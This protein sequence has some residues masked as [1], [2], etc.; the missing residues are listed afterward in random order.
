MKIF[1]K[2]VF[3]FLGILFC[4]LM[5]SQNTNFTKTWNLDDCIQYAS[6]H[7]ININSLKLNE[8]SSEQDVL[9]AKAIKTPSLNAL[10]NNIFHNSKN[11]VL[12]TGVYQNQL[13]SNGNYSLNA[14]LVLWNGNAINNNI[15]QKELLQ[16]TSNLLVTQSTNN[17][18]LA[19]TQSYLSVLLAKE[20][21]K[22]IDD[23]VLT[24]TAKVKQ[25][26]QLYDAGSAA[27]TNLLQ[28]QAQLANDN[29]LQIQA[30]NTIK[31]NLLSLKQLLQLPSETIFDITT[32]TS[33]EIG[34]AL[35]DLKQV[36]QNASENFPDVKIGQLGIDIAQLDISKAKAGFKPTLTATGTLG[37]GYNDVLSKSNIPSAGYFNQTSNN[38]Y[39]NIGLNLS[40]PI[41]SNR[42]NKTNLE[43]AKIG[44][45]QAEFNL[46]NNKLVL[47]QEVEQ[48]YLNSKNAQELYKSANQQLQ[49]V[50]EIYRIAN[51]QF[52]LGG[53]NNYD[54]LQ[55]K[56]QYIQAVQAFTQAK[57]SAILDQ[58]I[59]EFYNGNKI[60]F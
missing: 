25:E 29:Y 28:L 35:S 51:E 34:S 9:L 5:H 48:A 37:S 4:N 6:E 52:K 55:I 23:L 10:A 24:S 41:F 1:T 12:N 15:S 38:F 11:N 39:Q 2:Y 20:N 40:I 57:Y 7:N 36:Q 33:L 13:T 17:I 46:Q 30:T 43:K 32:P 22:Y 18:T 14:G 60:Q 58:K 3:S 53:I 16:K 31:Q 21:L 47:S 42:T 44:Y 49:S 45:N 56:N 54:L 8:K 50:V 26:Q 59:V 19:I 27:K